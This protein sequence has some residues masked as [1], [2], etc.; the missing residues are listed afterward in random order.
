MSIINKLFG[1]SEKTILKKYQLTV[2]SINVIEKDFE[3]F[4]D[5]ELK[6]KT[7][8]LKEEIEKEFDR[9][10]GDIKAIEQ[11][12]EDTVDQDNKLKIKAKLRKEKNKVFSNFLPEA[13]AL[14]REASKRTL[15]LRHFDVQLIGGLVLHEGGI[16]EM[17]TGEGKTLAATLAV[18]LNALEGKGSHIITVNDYLARRD[19]NWMAPIYHILGLSVGCIQHDSAFL[20][21][22][23]SE[24][25]ENEVSVE[26]ENLKPVSRAEAY[27]CDVTY[28]TN[29][30]FGF[31]YLRDNLVLDPNQMVQK[32][33]N[34]A[35]VDE[36]DSILIDEA[37]TPLIIS[38]PDMDSSNKYELVAQRALPHLEKIRFITSMEESEAKKLNTSLEEGFDIVANEERKSALLTQQGQDKCEK[39]LGV[40]GLFE[41]IE[42]ESFAW[43][44]AI[45]QAVKAKVFFNKDKDYVV[46]DGQVVIVDDFTG[47]LMPG[48]RY[49][50]G[51]HQA[52]EAKEGLKVQK[53]SKTVA[54]ITFQ[55]YFRFYEKLSGMTGTAVTNA[56]EFNRVYGLDVEVIPTNKPIIR[57]D[58]SDSIYKTEKGKFIAAAEKIKECNGNN[59]PV[60]VGTISV[61]KSEALSDLLAEKGVRHEILNAKNHEKEASIIAK[62]GEAG[63]VTIATNMAG[64]GTDIKISE[65]AKKAGGLF[66]LG[67]ERH[68]ARRIDNQLRGRS[69]RQGDEGASRFFVSLDDDLMR[70]FGSDRIRGMMDKLNFPEDQPIENKI[71]SKAIE[72]AQT[73]VE[74]Y[75]F[76]IRK[77]VLEYDDVMNKQRDLIYRRRR[78][79]L[80]AIKDEQR[81]NEIKNMAVDLLN[82]EIEKTVYSSLDKEGKINTAVLLNELNNIVGLKKDIFEKL[83]DLEISIAIQQIKD[84]LWEEYDKYEQ[85]L[86]VD[87]MRQLERLVLLRVIDMFWME[88]LDYMDYLR[89]SVSLRG[90]G[91]R[92]P[93]VEYRKEGFIA[94]ENL[95]SNIQTNF[96]RYI[97]RASFAQ[98]QAS[99]EKEKQQRK[100]LNY[101]GG[102]DSPSSAGV[103][104][105]NKDK[106]GRNDLCPC[107]S[108][109]KFKRCCGV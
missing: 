78:K 50:E 80:F 90:F 18:F 10:S 67:T 63:S 49:S 69:G 83:S 87:A 102:D 70:I 68:E 41:G 71:L 108:G 14:V 34:F 92:D 56:E 53:E 28:G 38:A 101:S 58:F 55:N 27:G 85:K 8:K 35:I 59:Q 89:N 48:R 31:D 66:V 54:T 51:L 12:L 88:H 11:E 3:K 5:T 72:S 52:I 16:A 91:Q 24:P 81:K 103:T 82:Q 39:A 40:N 96:S 13:F 25:D 23:Q 45:D 79:I 105:K 61:E 98:A 76:D 46:K 15:G 29:N 75:N 2:D 64:R 60:L 1:K 33:H 74:G 47:R 43:K 4:S 73:K 17:K 32:W 21:D 7:Q 77:H 104:I 42:Q 95:L 19:A 57:K 20:F 22:P 100:H 107:G 30:E 44:H 106:V 26:M 9:I 99:M 84:A 94:F 97:F 93:L 109:K 37:R 86:G 65:E 62:A 36:V 6:E